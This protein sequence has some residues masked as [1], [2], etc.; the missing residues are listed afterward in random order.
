MSRNK[1]R[2]LNFSALFRIVLEVSAR[3]IRQEKEIKGIQIV[4]EEERL[5]HFVDDIILRIKSPKESISKQ[6]Y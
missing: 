4:N 6:T 2:M 3:E 5:H 1:M